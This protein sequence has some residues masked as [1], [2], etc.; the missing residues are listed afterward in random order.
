[1]DDLSFR[2]EVHDK[3]PKTQDHVGGHINALSDKLGEA[4]EVV[5]R[6][7]KISREKQKAHYDKNTKLVTF[8]EG[9]YA[10]LN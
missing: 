3:E 5:T 9:D 8:S 4:Y 2:I 1:M 10:Y 7:N 6:L